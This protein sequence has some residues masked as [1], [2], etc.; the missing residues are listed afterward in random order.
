MRKYGFL[1]IFLVFP[2]INIFCLDFSTG[3]GGFIGYTFTRYIIEDEGIESI[4]KLDRADYAGF[5][6]F[7]FKY[8]D[9]TV[10]F[11][12]AK[13]NYQEVMS[14]DGLEISNDKGKGSE[15]S[16]GLSLTG[17]YPFSV[18]EKITLFPLFG[19]TYHF[20][21]AEKRKPE[22]YDKEF[23]RTEG[24]L[25]ADRDINDKPYPIYKWNSLWINV[26]GGIDYSITNS[27]FL[28]GELTFGFRMPTGYEMGALEY[29]RQELG[30]NPKLAG[31]GLTGNPT[32]KIGIGYRF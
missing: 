20:A 19:L 24:I 9:F 10:L 2:V 14:A 1:L 29:I 32:I 23:S 27:L 17:K 11:R 26:G 25:A 21:L 31:A 16:L 4:Q 8:G 28:R 13:N 3:G 12:G 6:F 7:D 15:M 5:L 30:I 22:G 18:N